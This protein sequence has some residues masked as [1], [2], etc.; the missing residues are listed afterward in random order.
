MRCNAEESDGNG[1][2]RSE[3]APRV[4]LRWGELVLDPDR[5]NVVAVGLTGAL[6]WAGV[7]MMW[8][9]FIVTMAILI[10]AINEL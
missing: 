10:A 5:N 9:L 4:N 1:P 2:G 7:W 6:A 3:E 8:Q